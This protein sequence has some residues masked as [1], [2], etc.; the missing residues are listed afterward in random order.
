MYI[1]DCLKFDSQCIYFSIHHSP[2]GKPN[3]SSHPVTAGHVA[4]DQRGA[5]IGGITCGIG[6]GYELAILPGAWYS[7]PASGP[8]LN[9]TSILCISGDHRTIGPGP[10]FCIIHPPAPW[11]R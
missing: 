9:G 3:T 5:G 7:G 4:G 1:L 8:G 11:P 10:V 6:Y 2:G